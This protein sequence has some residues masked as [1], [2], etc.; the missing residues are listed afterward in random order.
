MANILSELKF[1]R[2]H[3]AFYERKVSF[4]L[5]SPII[6]SLG[7]IYLLSSLH[8][9]FQVFDNK[10]LFSSSGKISSV[11]LFDVKHIAPEST[12]YVLE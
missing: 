8:R 4:S 10:T 9:F 3:L 12:K 1:T 2:S 11:T 5:I 6:F 7:L